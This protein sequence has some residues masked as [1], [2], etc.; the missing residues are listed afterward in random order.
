[1]KTMHHLNSVDAALL[2]AH[3][4]RVQRCADVQMCANL[5]NIDICANVQMCKDVQT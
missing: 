1:M 4:M 5:Q 3:L 2:A